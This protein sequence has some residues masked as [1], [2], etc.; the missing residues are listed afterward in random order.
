MMRLDEAIDAITKGII[1][2]IS[3]GEEIK[4]RGLGTF[5]IKRKKETQCSHP[6]NPGEVIAIP[7]KTMLKFV[8]SGELKEAAEAAGEFLKE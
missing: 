8:P 2:A 4:L 1:D 3:E 7:G 6:K 5:K